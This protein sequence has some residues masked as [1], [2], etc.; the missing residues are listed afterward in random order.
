MLIVDS[1]AVTMVDVV[2]ELAG[3]KE[4]G[5]EQCRVIILAEA[6]SFCISCV[7]QRAECAGAPMQAVSSQRRWG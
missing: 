3:M 1:R 7:R 4:E 6:V 2:Q 5:R